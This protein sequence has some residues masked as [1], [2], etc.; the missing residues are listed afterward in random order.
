MNGSV[1]IYVVV[2]DFFWIS[3]DIKQY[4][5]QVYWRDAYDIISKKKNEEK[6]EY[7]IIFCMKYVEFALD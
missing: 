6:R 1:C 5:S 3:I 4:L 2:V 7:Y